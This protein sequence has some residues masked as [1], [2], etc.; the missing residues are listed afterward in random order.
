MKRFPAHVLQYYVVE[1]TR[2]ISNKYAFAPM[3]ALRM[4]IRSETYR[5]LT[6]P[7]L[8]MWEFSPLIILDLWENEKV[9]G[10]PRTSV[11]IRSE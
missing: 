7:E 10:D 9:T 5:M 2:Q 11:F 6:D 1:V 8:E 3:E 4:F